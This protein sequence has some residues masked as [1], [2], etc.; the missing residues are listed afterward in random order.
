MRTFCINHG[1]HFEGTYEEMIE[2]VRENYQ[3]ED[4]CC[5]YD[6]E[7]GHDDGMGPDEI[8]EEEAA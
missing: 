3:C 4:F 5:V 1:E 8:F 6:I 2:Y 7:D